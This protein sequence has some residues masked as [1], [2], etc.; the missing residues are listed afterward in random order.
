MGGNAVLA[1][2][3]NLIE[4]IALLAAGGFFLYKLIDGWGLLNLSL[5]LKANR[6]ERNEL[7]LVVIT[8]KLSK[9]DR[10]SVELHSVELRCATEDR[11]PELVRIPLIHPL[12]LKLDGDLQ[13]DETRVKWGQIDDDRPPIHLPPGEST[14]YSHVFRVPHGALCS[15]EALVI[16]KRPLSTRR[17]QWRASIAVA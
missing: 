10:G 5:E 1:D 7:D 12:K 6:K 3:R 8:L 16:G 2:A 15:V 11:E 4:I 17:G 13:E 9:G 14:E